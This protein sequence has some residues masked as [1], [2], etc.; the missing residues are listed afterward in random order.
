MRLQDMFD[1]I[2]LGYWWI[3]LA[4]S[5]GQVSTAHWLQRK[6]SYVSLVISYVF[7]LVEEQHMLFRWIQ[8]GDVCNL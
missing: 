2:G 4:A 1:T 6:Y 5:F 3:S 7:I 8:H